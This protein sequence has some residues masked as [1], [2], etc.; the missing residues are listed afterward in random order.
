MQCYACENQPRE[1]PCSICAARLLASFTPATL[2]VLSMHRVLW[3]GLRDLPVAGRAY[4]QRRAL[5]KILEAALDASPRVQVALVTMID[6]VPDLVN[7]DA[8]EA[9]P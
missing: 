8:D 5:L 6:H 9:A 1:D 2:R 7:H 4:T 3:S